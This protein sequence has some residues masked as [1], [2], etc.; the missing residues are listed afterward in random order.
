MEKSVVVDVV[1]III[2]SGCSHGEALR[3][4][5]ESRHQQLTAEH[6]KSFRCSPG[7]FKPTNLEL[8]KHLTPKP[9]S[10]IGCFQRAERSA[11]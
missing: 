2:D 7:G 8:L 6:C 9:H 1:I 11:G 5:R 3:A 10:G 4:E